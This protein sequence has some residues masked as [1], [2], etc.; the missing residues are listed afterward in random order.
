[1]K[2]KVLQGLNVSNSLKREREDF[3]QQKENKKRKDM[4]PKAFVY[5]WFVPGGYLSSEAICNDVSLEPSIIN[6]LN[7][8]LEDT[9]LN[10]HRPPSSGEFPVKLFNRAKVR[11]QL[12]PN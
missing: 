5:F 1:M 12:I 3:F 2:Y 7:L 10:W 8:V 9:C 11:S 6:Y 4:Y